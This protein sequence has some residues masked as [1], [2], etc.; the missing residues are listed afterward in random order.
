MQGVLGDRALLVPE[1]CGR[2]VAALTLERDLRRIQR[3]RVALHAVIERA[4]AQ[5]E[6]LHGGVVGVLRRLPPVLDGNILIIVL[7]VAEIARL[8][9]VFLV[10]VLERELGGEL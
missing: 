5:L 4:K 1:L 6:V 9:F 3:A 10:R 7:V 8:V 2:E